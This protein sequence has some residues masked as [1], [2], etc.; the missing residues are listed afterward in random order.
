LLGSV[1]AAL[2]ALARCH[3]LSSKAARAGFDW[4]GVA[5]VREAVGRELAELDAEIALGELK[6]PERQ[7]RLRHELGDA[8]M[9][10]ANL[11]RHLG[12]SGEKALC[13]ANDRFVSRFGRVERALAEK[14]LRPEDAG[15][16]EL[17]RLWAEAKKLEKSS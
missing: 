15:I 17:E 5:E 9:A 13:E 3:R 8:L 7:A 12:F 1:P 6:G 16:E 14:S 4:P 11:A 2:P 10:L